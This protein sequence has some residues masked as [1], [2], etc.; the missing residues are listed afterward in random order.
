MV[1]A[2]LPPMGLLLVARLYP[3]NPRWVRGFAYFMF[4]VCTVLVV[5]I[6][7]DR[8]F[9]TASVCLIV[10][11]RYH[12]PTPLY[13]AYG[14][15]Y[16]SGL[17]SMLL[18]SANG[19]TNSED[20]HTRRLLGQVLLGSIAFIVPSLVTVAVVPVAEAAL[21][22]IMCH[23]ALL[24]AIFLTRLA[25]MERHAGSLLDQSTPLENAHAN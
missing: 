2:W 18:L 15:F 7:V 11:A 4:L 21:P 25:W 8:N 10:F 12:N 14:I 1:V 9:V 3:D 5:G 22:S 19:V 20:S 23:F 6:A 13:Q 17:L 24:L 16:Q